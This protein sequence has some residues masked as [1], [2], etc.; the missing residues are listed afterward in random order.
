MKELQIPFRE[1][2]EKIAIFLKENGGLSNGFRTYVQGKV[3]QNTHT[4][5][6]WE[7]PEQDNL[8]IKQVQNLGSILYEQILR[9][10]TIYDIESV[11]IKRRSIGE[12]S[13]YETVISPCYEKIVNL[14]W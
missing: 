1:I 13:C 6:N 5:L 7:T 3:W 11:E 14:N 10:L 8:T 9:I 12:S 4:S 2:G